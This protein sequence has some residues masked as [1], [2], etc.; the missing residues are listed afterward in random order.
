MFAT[1][2]NG[3]IGESNYSFDHGDIHVAVINSMYDLDEQ[4]EWLIDD[5]RASDQ[6]WKV[7]VG[8]FSYFGGHHA[9]DPK[10]VEDRAE[11]APVLQQLGVDLYIGGHDHAYKRSTIIDGHLAQTPEE[12]LFGTTYVTMGS[13][14]PKF[15]DNE[16]FPW[17]D[18]VFDEDTQVGMALQE[19]ADG[20]R[21]EVRTID[22]RDRRRLP[23]HPTGLP[24]G[25]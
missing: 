19:T 14:G 10:V 7:V 3:V 1:P 13:T 22:G 25:M 18:V 9:G 17:D 4:L 11:V 16:V 21:F 20:L 23:H 6:P 15:Y 2:D 24:T 8:H 5:M 12:E